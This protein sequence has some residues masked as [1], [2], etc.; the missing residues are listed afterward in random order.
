MNF[1]D[2]VRTH[3][4]SSHTLVLAGSLQLKKTQNH[5]ILCIAALMMG[6]RKKGCM[7]LPLSFAQQI[8]FPL[9]G[10]VLDLP[11]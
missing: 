2:T 7:S 4:P 3:L 9:K 8:S 1:E 10:S 6:V 11:I 5:K